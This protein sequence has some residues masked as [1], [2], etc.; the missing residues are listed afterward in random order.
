VVVGGLL[1]SYVMQEGHPAPIRVSDGAV[2]GLFAGTIGAFI[3]TALAALFAAIRGL[4]RQ[5]VLDETLEALRDMPAD[6]RASLEQLRSLPESGWLLL[7]LT[8]MLMVGVVF[9][10][11][12]GVIGAVIFRG[13]ASL[14]PQ[15]PPPSRPSDT[16][17][18]LPGPPAS[19]T[20]G[21]SG[22]GPV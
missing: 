14:P 15:A 8:G 18:Q 20:D 10:T 16:P 12:G 11:A 5:V 4:D 19:P 17:T 13:R 1:T 21:E 22:A 6:M 3:S 2:G 7:G 9:A